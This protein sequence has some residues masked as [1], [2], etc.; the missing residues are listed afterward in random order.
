MLL[1]I[2]DDYRGEAHRHEFLQLR[3]Q[4]AQADGVLGARKSAHFGAIFTGLE[5]LGRTGQSKLRVTRPAKAARVERGSETTRLP[6][7]GRNLR[8]VRYALVAARQDRALFESR[9]PYATG[10]LVLNHRDIV[11]KAF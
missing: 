8:V 2:G 4:I 3:C 7:T 11:E 9:E 6:L 10:L 1:S 5:D